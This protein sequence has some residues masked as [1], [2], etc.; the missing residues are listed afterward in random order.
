M[1][2][3]IGRNLFAL[4]VGLAVAVLAFQWITDPLP[5]E[6]RQSEE[7]AVLASR[8]LLAAQIGG[9]D[10]LEIVD[11]LAPD[12]QVGKVYIYAEGPGWAVSGYYRRGG[13]DRWHPY[14]MHLTADLGLHSLKAD[15]DAPGV[16]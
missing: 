9:G 12:R 13:A 14:L 7:K 11:P 4:C 5:R 15:D 10:D 3:R 6:R 1:N 16:R 2:H 8:D